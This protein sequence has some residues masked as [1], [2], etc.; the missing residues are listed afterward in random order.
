MMR[1]RTPQDF[2]NDAKEVHMDKFDYSEVNYVNRIT[3]VKIICPKHGEFFQNPNSHLSGKIGCNNCRGVFV[4]DFESFLQKEYNYFIDLENREL[5]G[6]GLRINPSNGLYIGIGLMNEV[7]VY[8]YS[9]IEH[10]NLKS[11][12]YINHS[13][14]PNEFMAIRNIIYYQF[15]STNLGHYRILWDGNINIEATDKISF[16]L[17]LKFHSF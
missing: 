6:G 15:K 17:N 14:K 13:F 3:K 1:K 9:S 4:T 16:H 2:I 10:V 5:I 12:N 11:T 7:E 8:Q